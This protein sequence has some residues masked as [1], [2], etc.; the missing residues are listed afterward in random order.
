MKQFYQQSW[1]KTAVKFLIQ[2]IIITVALLAITVA[3]FFNLMVTLAE[4]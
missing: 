1:F 4:A 3:V 2:S